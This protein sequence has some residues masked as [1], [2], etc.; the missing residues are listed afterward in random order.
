MSRRDS[1]ITIQYPGHYR[2]D[3]ICWR[4]FTAGLTP[5]KVADKSRQNG[6]RGVSKD[7]VTLAMDGDCGTLHKLWLIACAMDLN[8]SELF[9][10]DLPQSEFDRAVKGKAARSSGPAKVGVPQ[11]RSVK[12]GGTY[13]RV[14]D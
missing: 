11:A 10:F 8:F 1:G 4:M 12:R 5:R 7:T 2:H 3:I 14:R 9:N 13:T 6:E